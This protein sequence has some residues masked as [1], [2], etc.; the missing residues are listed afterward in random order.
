MLFLGSLLSPVSISP[1]PFG[2]P[3]AFS[4]YLVRFERFWFF[5]LSRAVFLSLEVVSAAL[6]A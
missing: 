1:A 2:R 6:N 4:Q 5:F 3:A